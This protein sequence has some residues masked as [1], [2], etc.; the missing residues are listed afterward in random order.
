MISG[1][2]GIAH[3]AS[4]HFVCK[5]EERRSLPWKKQAHANT[6]IAICMLVKYDTVQSLCFALFATFRARS[7]PL[8]QTICPDDSPAIIQPCHR[9]S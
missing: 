2:I 3:H 8:H 7:R 5:P 9:D 4:L 6:R 1:Y